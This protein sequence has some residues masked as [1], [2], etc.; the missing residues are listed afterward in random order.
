MFRECL[1]AQWLCSDIKHCII[2]VEYIFYIVIY[3]SKFVS[4]FSKDFSS[5]LG[6]RDI[7]IKGE[8]IIT[9]M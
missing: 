3:T 2:N 7:S 1:E 8:G 5:S 6:P 4:I 9:Y